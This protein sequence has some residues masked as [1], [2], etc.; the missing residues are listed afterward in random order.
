MINTSNE[1]TADAGWETMAAYRVE[2]QRRQQ[3]PGV[4]TYRTRV[5]HAQSRNNQ[6]WRG[7]QMSTAN[8][9][10]SQHFRGLQLPEDAYT[11]DPELYVQ[12]VRVQVLQPPDTD[13]PQIICEGRHIIC[14]VIQ[15]GQAFKLQVHFIASD[16]TPHN[17]H[18][19][20]AQFYVYNRDSAGFRHLGTS[21]LQPYFAE[22]EGYSLT[23]EGAQLEAG[24]YR[25]E[26][27]VRI[28]CNERPMIGYV[29]VPVLQVI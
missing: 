15:A 3:S 2:F 14:G 4:Y 28:H 8:R 23:L 19:Y 27:V 22:Q 17:P 11:T 7:L 29:E 21:A 20:N 6:T 16:L 13:Q 10:L 12:I 26:I 5:A 25:M 24:N 18:S 1:Q 9:W